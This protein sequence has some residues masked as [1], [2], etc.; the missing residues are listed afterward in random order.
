MYVISDCGTVFVNVS[1]KVCHKSSSIKHG[2]SCS[3]PRKVN[4]LGRSIE[5]FGVVKESSHY[6]TFIVTSSS[7]Y[8]TRVFSRDGK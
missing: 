3:I 5:H 6:I 2:I 8:C 4:N 7:I 1:R